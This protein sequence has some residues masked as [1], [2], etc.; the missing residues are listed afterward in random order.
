MLKLLLENAELTQS[1]Y[2]AFSSQDVPP[3]DVFECLPPPPESG[4]MRNNRFFEIVIWILK[5]FI[6]GLLF[7]IVLCSGIAAK[8]AVLLI[9]AQLRKNQSLP[10]CNRNLGKILI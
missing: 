9:T 2:M 10:F 1:D 3:W 5:V 4:S 7:T 6:Y 8:L